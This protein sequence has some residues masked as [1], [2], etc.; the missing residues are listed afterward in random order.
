MLIIIRMKNRQTYVFAV[1]YTWYAYGEV[2][3]Y[4]SQYSGGSAWL[5]SALNIHK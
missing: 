2:I 5:C 4:L 3:I 1:A